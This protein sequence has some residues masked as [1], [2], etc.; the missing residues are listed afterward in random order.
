MA[1]NRRLLPFLLV[2]PCLGVFLHRPSNPQGLVRQTAISNPFLHQRKL[3][4]RLLPLFLSALRLADFQRGRLQVKQDMVGRRVLFLRDTVRYH[5]VFLHRM[6]YLLPVLALLLALVV[7]NLA[8]R[9]PRHHTCL[10]AS[11]VMGFA[12][13]YHQIAADHCE[14]QMSVLRWLLGGYMY[15]EYQ[16]RSTNET[17]NSHIEEIADRK[18]LKKLWATLINI[19]PLDADMAMILP[20]L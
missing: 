7:L 20:A 8:L 1:S 12:N 17:I 4:L 13:E 9:R 15:P 11:L 2:V 18:A 10:Q 14:C 3:D 5:L 19:H 16:R 6:S